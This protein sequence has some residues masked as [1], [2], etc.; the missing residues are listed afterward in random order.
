MS[1]RL[2]DEQRAW[3]SLVDAWQER[4]EL[5][6]AD[7]E[8]L[9]I[10]VI[11]ETKRMR[12][13]WVVEITMSAAAVAFVV[14]YAM[15]A[16]GP[17]SRFALVDTFAVLAIVWSFAAWGR[18]GLWRPS[19]ETSQAYVALAKRRTRLK[20]WTT[21]LVLVLVVGQLAATLVFHLGLSSLQAI[22][23]A[24]WLAWVFWMRRRAGTELRF[25]DGIERGRIIPP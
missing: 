25:Y 12:G 17:R 15:R 18:R 4:D 23:A 8:A 24:A 1:D 21:W 13:W 5:P 16:P 7:P 2:V 6:R 20:L 14:A 22:A 11:R 9:R 19:A 10:S 3:A